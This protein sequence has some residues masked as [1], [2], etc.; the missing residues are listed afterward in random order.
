MNLIVDKSNNIGAI[1][2]LI[3][4]IHCIATPFLFISKLCTETCCENTPIWWASIDYVFMFISL[5]AVYNSSRLSNNSTIIIFMWL[6][7]FTLFF[8]LINE[9]FN[10]VDLF[11]YAIYIPTISLIILH[12]YNIKYCKCNSS[13]CCVNNK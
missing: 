13:K 7:W 4:L 9:Q 1:A 3:C 12:I 8:I 11:N 5:I 2:S 10:V 6:S